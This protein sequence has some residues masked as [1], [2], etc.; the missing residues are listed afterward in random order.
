MAIPESD[1]HGRRH[2]SFEIDARDDELG[3]NDTIDSRSTLDDGFDSETL[4]YVAIGSAA[5]MLGTIGVLAAK[6]LHDK[7]KDS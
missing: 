7:R 5:A 2:R 6:R 4:K 3:I 1:G